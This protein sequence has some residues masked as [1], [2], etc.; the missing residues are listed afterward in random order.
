MCYVQV[1]GRRRRRPSHA[2]RWPASEKRQ[3]TK[4]RRRMVRRRAFASSSGHGTLP[5]RAAPATSQ[6]HF[7]Q[8]GTDQATALVQ[9][10]GTPLQAIAPKIGHPLLMLPR[11]PAENGRIR[12]R[13]S[14]W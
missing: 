11:W 13:G 8:V 3:G 14:G 10:G 9:L 1:F 6:G 2:L 5:V 7:W 12:S 4:S